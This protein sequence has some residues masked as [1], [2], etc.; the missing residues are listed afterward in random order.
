[1]PRPSHRPASILYSSGSPLAPRDTGEIGSA[2]NL[3]K[4]THSRPKDA[5]DFPNYAELIALGE[6]FNIYARVLRVLP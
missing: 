5:D 6:R 2:L 4:A 3:L 1:M